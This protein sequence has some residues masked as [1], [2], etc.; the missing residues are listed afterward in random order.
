MLL[1]FRVYFVSIP[2]VFR[3]GMDLNVYVH[4]DN[5]GPVTVTARLHNIVSPNVNE[6]SMTVM[7]EKVVT[8]GT[9]NL[10]LQAKHFLLLVIGY[11]NVISFIHDMTC[12]NK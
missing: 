4:V 6:A 9:F 11:N 2:K 8:P 7:Q 12:C 10:I 3:P 5:T 1:Y